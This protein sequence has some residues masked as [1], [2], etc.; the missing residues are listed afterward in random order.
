MEY[1]TSIDV[2][3]PLTTS[4]GRG[5]ES[6]E[7]E[8]G[9]KDSGTAYFRPPLATVVVRGSR[10]I[11]LKRLDGGGPADWSVRVCRI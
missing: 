9:G 1:S 6:D 4:A 10:G 8:S 11:S 3:T 7:F 2:N 5:N